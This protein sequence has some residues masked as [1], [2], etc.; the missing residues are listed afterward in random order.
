MLSNAALLPLRP[1]ATRRLL[2]G[3]LLVAAVLGT[4][5]AATPSAAEARTGTAVMRSS[6]LSAGQLVSWFRSSSTRVAGY[7]ATVSVET[8]AA[9]YIEEGRAEGVAGDLAFAQAVLETG[10]FNWPGHGQVRAEQ[11][12]FAGIGACDG[13]TCTVAT[14]RSARIGVRAQIQHLRAY[15]DPNVTRDNLAHPLESPRFDLVDPKGKASTWE[16]MGGGN[17]A[18]DPHYSTK[19][20]NLYGA[21]R[22]HAGLPASSTATVSSGFVGSFRD[23][24][25]THTHATSIAS[26]AERGITTGCTSTAFCPSD[27]V[28]RAQM[29]TFLTRA[30]ALPAGPSGVFRDVSGPHQRGI[31][32]VA[33]A[34]VTRGCAPRQFC[35]NERI[36]REQVASLLQRELNLPARPAPFRDVSSG[37]THAGAIGALAEAGIIR[38]GKDGT[39]DPKAPVTR[40]Q[41]ASFLARAYPA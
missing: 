11:N 27:H 22:Q 20:L 12:N 35:P 34:G 14:F 3:L 33:A 15:A 36:T 9:L 30:A 10:S 41:M 5:V 16:Q 7:R 24:P 28:T 39:F 23:V 1:A 37:S 25:W 26:L 18:T 40:A 32:A 21:M 6:Q 17:W 31:E 29:A 8:L 38:G 19:I 2:A 13:G 4:S